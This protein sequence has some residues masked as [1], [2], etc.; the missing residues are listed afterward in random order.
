M[1]LAVTLAL[2]ATLS[3]APL[4][5]WAQEDE[6]SSDAECVELYAEGFECVSGSLGNYCVEDRCD[7]DRDCEEDYGEDSWCESWGTESHCVVDD[8]PAYVPPFKSICTASTTGNQPSDPVSS[9][10]FVFLAAW[11]LARRQPG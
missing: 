8:P 3:L 7:T 11:L 6:C 9:I 2:G 10:G 1:K 4:F 5:A